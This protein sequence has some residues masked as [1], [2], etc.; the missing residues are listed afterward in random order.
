MY[1]A[2]NYLVYKSLKK[3]CDITTIIDTIWI[4]YIMFYNMTFKTPAKKK[5]SSTMIGGRRYLKSV[6]MHLEEPFVSKQVYT[7]GN[8]VM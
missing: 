3:K 5:N 6:D 1:F 4:S 8:L 7:W 2:L